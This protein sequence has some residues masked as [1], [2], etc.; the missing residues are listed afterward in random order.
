MHICACVIL[1]I[2]KRHTQIIHSWNCD[3][4]MGKKNQL[5]FSEGKIPNYTYYCVKRLKKKKGTIRVKLLLILCWIIFQLQLIGKYFKFIIYKSNSLIKYLWFRY[6][7][8]L[9]K[10]K[11]SN[12]SWLCNHFN[13]VVSCI[14]SPFVHYNI[15][16]KH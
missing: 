4:R 16:A 3:G 7:F 13:E 15:E 12:L 14:H 8:K 2:D 10:V 11:L 9:L 5:R 6:W 1:K